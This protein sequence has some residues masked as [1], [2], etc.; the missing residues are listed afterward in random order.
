MQTIATTELQS[1]L[2]RMGVATNARAQVHG[3]GRGEAEWRQEDLKTEIKTLA[4][5]GL[6]DKPYASEKI[7]TQLAHQN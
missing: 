7:G 3:V 6:G 4:E 5:I 2:D 1:A